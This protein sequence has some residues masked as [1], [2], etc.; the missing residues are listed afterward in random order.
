MYVHICPYMSIYVEA[1]KNIHKTYMSA[2]MYPY[3][4]HIHV[5]H[6]CFI[7]VLLDIRE[8][9]CSYKNIPK[10]KLISTYIHIRYIYEIL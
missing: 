8:H 9:I 2:Y 4:E 5:V 7:Y 10:V 1:Y 6:I 3:M